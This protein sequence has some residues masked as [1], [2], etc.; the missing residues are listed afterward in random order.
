ML[1]Y[2]ALYYDVIPLV[3]NQGR[4][5]YSIA[6]YNMTH[7]FIITPPSPAPNNCCIMNKYYLTIIFIAPPH[8]KSTDR[9]TKASEI[10]QILED[11]QESYILGVRKKILK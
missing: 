5:L 8:K 4:I 11:N 6:L 9:W 2:W 3:V 1:V 10:N 7:L